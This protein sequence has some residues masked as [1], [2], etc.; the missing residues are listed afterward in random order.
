MTVPLARAW[1]IGAADLEYFF[2]PTCS[3]AVHGKRN[4]NLKCDDKKRTTKNNMARHPKIAAVPI[5]ID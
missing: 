5:S 3:S 1:G 2:T 4:S